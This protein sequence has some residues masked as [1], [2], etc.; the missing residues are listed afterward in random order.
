MA[1]MTVEKYTQKFTVLEMLRLI[2]HV[3]G[4]KVSRKEECNKDLL[5]EKAA[6]LDLDEDDTYEWLRNYRSRATGGEGGGE[7][8][9]GEGE[10][11]DEDEEENE[12]EEDD[13]GE[14]EEASETNNDDDEDIP[15]PADETDGE[16]EDEIEKQSDKETTETSTTELNKEDVVDNVDEFA[17]YLQRVARTIEKLKRPSEPIPDSMFTEVSYLHLIWKIKTKTIF[18]EVS[19]ENDEQA[20]WPDGWSTSEKEAV[21]HNLEEYSKWKLKPEN[22]FRFAM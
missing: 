10:G 6:T 7:A 4:Q 1:P 14:D 21:V 16:N 15:Q 12:G 3:H 9:G 2:R 13:E 8:G 17:E 18:D 19:S 11:E 20:F 22:M 5:A